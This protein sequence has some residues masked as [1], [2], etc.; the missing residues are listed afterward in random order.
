MRNENVENYENSRQKLALT[1]ICVSPQFSY[2]ISSSLACVYRSIRQ[3]FFKDGILIGRY[4]VSVCRQIGDSVVYMW[5]V[6]SIELY[7]M[8]IVSWK[9]LVGDNGVWEELMSVT[10]IMNIFHWVYHVW[11][12][13]ANTMGWMADLYITHFL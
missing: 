13:I 5:Y 6:Q 2:R 12:D 11:V 3:T 4:A 1:S 10:A 7:G 9:P 8:M